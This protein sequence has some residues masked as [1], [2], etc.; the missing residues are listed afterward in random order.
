MVARSV[1]PER[2]FSR[3]IFTLHKFPKFAEAILVPG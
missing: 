1:A 3:T 2:G